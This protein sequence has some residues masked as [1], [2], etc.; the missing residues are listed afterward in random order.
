MIKNPPANTGEVGDS[1]FILELGRSPWNRKWQLTPVFLPGRSHGYR[2]LAGY[3][4]WSHKES[5]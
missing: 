3:G 1:G 2:S 5:D 4:P